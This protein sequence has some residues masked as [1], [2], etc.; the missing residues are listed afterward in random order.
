MFEK[1]T[2]LI[3]QGDYKEALYEF[4]EEFLHIDEIPPM[5]AARLCV[6]EAT[7]WETL[8]DP[9]AEFD[10]MAQS[11]ISE[12]SNML[13]ANAATNLTGMGFEVDI[14]T[15]SLSIGKN[16]QVKISDSQYLTVEMDLGG[17]IVELDIAVDQNN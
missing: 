9:V 13:T 10:A 2:D 1:L 6:L 4:Q 16:F 14:S 3:T 17:H 7:L 8:E 15:P 12:M 11:A 5:D